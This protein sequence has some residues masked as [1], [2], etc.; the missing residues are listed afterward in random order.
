MV[1]PRKGYTPPDPNSKRSQKRRLAESQGRRRHN[2]QG[3][4]GN[5]RTVIGVTGLKHIGGRIREEYLNAIKNWN[6]EVKLYLEMRD[7]PI[8]GALTDAIKLPLQAAQFD[9]EPAPGGSP[10]DEAAAEWLWK[11]MNNMDGQTWISHVEDALECLDFGFALGEIVLD[12]RA[13]GRLWLKNIDPRGQE[14]LNRWEYDPTEKDKLISFIQNDPN[15]GAT[16]EIP[17]SKCVHFR[18]RGRKG[19]PQ[20]HSILR[21]L[22]RP[23]K[24]ARNL[25]DL[26]GIG[27]ER[28]VGGMPYAKL[29]DDNYEDEDLE[30]LKKALKG[31]RKDEEVYLIAPPGVDIQAYGGGTKIYDTNVVIDRWHK[32]TLM[33]FFAQFIILGMGN[34][35]TQ[36]LVKGSQDFFTLGLEAVQ[37]YLLETWNLQLVPY[38][39]KFNTWSG[40]SG[41]PEIVWEKPGKIDLNALITALNTAKG[42]GIFTPTDIDEDHLRAIAD[43]PELPEE[44][45]GGP[46]DVEQPPLGGLFDLPEKFDRLD[47]SVGNI[48]KELAAAGE[49]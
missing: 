1:E 36:A 47:K 7:D 25:E 20:G 15:W 29:T 33:R 48:E 49:K 34:V 45:R 28:D 30:D 31:L 8:I 39:F 6:T 13:D 40:I 19:N 18:Y 14:S 38:L 41:Y 3:D 22:Y 44:E 12:K 42:A 11:A 4:G 9:V 43:L 5:T 46:R 32:I 26:E 24:F 2:H 17:I 21:A 35:G 23:Y 37:R 27:I 10:N 16:Y